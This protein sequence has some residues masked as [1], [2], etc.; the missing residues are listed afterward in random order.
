M[1]QSLRQRARST[2]VWIVV[3]EQDRAQRWAQSYR[4]KTGDKGGGCDGNCKLLE[5]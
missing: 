3:L 4:N 5:E 2:L 1:K